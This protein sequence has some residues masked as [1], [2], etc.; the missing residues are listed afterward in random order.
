MSA[1]VVKGWCPG[2]RRPMAS[3]DGLVAR[4]R[5][6]AG[7]LSRAQA[8]GLCDLAERFGTGVLD[9]TSRANLQ[10]RGIAEAAHPALL[11]GLE[12]LGLLDPDPMIEARRNILTAPDHAPGRLTARLHDALV[13]RLGD[14]PDLPAKMGIALDLGPVPRLTGAS[15]DFRFEL[16]E[17]GALILRA[18]GAAAGR[19]VRPAEAPDA[20]IALARWFVASDG[21]EAGRMARHLARTALPAAWRATP[22]RAG[23]TPLEPGPY[24][25]GMAW[26]APFGAIPTAALRPLLAGA[27]AMRLAPGRVFAL[28]G[29]APRDIPGLIADPASP[30]LR[31]HACPG[32]PFCPQ[33]TVETRALAAALAP[34]IAGDLHVSGCAKGCARPGPAAVTLTGRDGRFDLI[35]DGPAGAAPA[36]SSLAPA[37]L[38][39]LFGTEPHAL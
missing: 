4:V 11:D 33:G 17:A 3:G 34:R 15:A 6:W 23:N 39:D 12:A 2:A 35:I 31:A 14:L 7:A 25:G 27:Q 16:S 18:D 26:G 19:E 29:A 37:Q 24:P 10:I 36:R 13:A 9:L 38:L 20:L 8:L 21:R 1:P 28:P 22:P 32:A 5:P 30:L